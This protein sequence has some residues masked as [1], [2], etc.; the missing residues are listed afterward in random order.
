MASLGRPVRRHRRGR[1]WRPPERRRPAAASP[2]PPST[3]R[4]P[5]AVDGSAGRP[6]RAYA[7]PAYS[8]RRVTSASRDGAPRRGTACP[9][10]GVVPASRR[11][12]PARAGAA[13]DP[14]GQRLRRPG[15][16]PAA[17]GRVRRRPVATRGPGP[18]RS[19][20]DPPCGRPTG[21]R[22]R[23][24]RPEPRRRPCPSAPTASAPDRARRSGWPGVGASARVGTSARPASTRARSAGSAASAPASECS[25]ATGSCRP[26]GR[27]AP[28]HGGAGTAAVVRAAARRSARWAS[29][30]HQHRPAARRRS[31]R[32][33]RSRWAENWPAAD[34]RPAGH[35][36]AV[37]QRDEQRPGRT[38]GGRAE[39]RARR[40]RAARRAASAPISSAEP[41]A[42]SAPGQ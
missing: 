38:G 26:A 24:G 19:T 8:C 18:A 21:R 17:G 37:G 36:E 22:S 27:P 40:D 9:D 13:G 11:A 15:R 3:R 2:R 41:R 4:R 31:P 20:A 35:G 16:A 30:G 7:R 32:T 23:R 34:R 28:R 29:D 1:P 25:P 12:E 10:P 42:S 6:P 39:P 5:S 14:G 33:G